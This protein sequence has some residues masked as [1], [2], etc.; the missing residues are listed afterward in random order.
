MVLRAKVCI[1][2][3]FFDICFSHTFE[4]GPSTPPPVPAAPDL[5]TT[6]LVELTDPARLRGE[7]GDPH[8][9]IRPPEL[10]G[11]VPVVAP[12]GPL[13]WE[14]HKAPLELL[15]DR[16]G[17]TPLPTPA[18]VRATATTSATTA[19]DWF[20]PGQFVHLSDDQALNRPAYELL[21]SGLR[22]AGGPGTDGPAAQATLEI[23][24][25]RL[26]T[27]AVR[28]TRVTAFPTWLVSGPPRKAAPL[29]VVTTEAWTVAGPGGVV[30]G[31]SGAQ[32]RRLA[33]L[34]T[35]AQAVPSTDQ[36][37]EFTF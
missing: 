12:V 15:L 6:L 9:H 37:P 10:G 8:V 2:L 21:P 35:T 14:Q 27:R 16:F 28:P 24:E 19:A 23:T 18:Q 36:L 1:E 20:A 3:L 30:N 5:L 11:A 33:D 7:S 4:L 22:L 13:V 29:V 31:L 26:P 34:T 17:G 25:I 32:A